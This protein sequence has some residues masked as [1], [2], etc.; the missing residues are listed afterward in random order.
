M[1]DT[2]VIALDPG[3]GGSNE[4]LK[5]QGLIEKEMTNV[6]AHTMKDTLLQY[7]QVEVYI[8]N[9]DKAD[10]SLKQRAEY[11][12]S[13]GADIVISLHFNMSENHE[14]FG[15]EVW[16]PSSGLG[17]ARMRALG[18]VFMEQ[19]DEM[20]MTL[21]GVKT[22]LNDRGSDYY[23]IIRESAALGIP[24]I[25]VEHGYADHAMDFEKVNDPEDW[26]A[27]AVSDAT[28]VAKY[29]RLKSSSLGNDYSDHVKNGY[30]APEQ[31]IGS[32]ATE[33]Q[34][35]SIRWD[36][37]LELTEEELLQLQSEQTQK[38]GEDSPE[39]W[40]NVQLFTIGATEEES[41]LVYYSYSYDGGETFSEVYPFA[42]DAL[43]MQIQIPNVYPG[44]QVCVR[45]YN[46]HFLY[47]TTDTITFQS[48]D[49]MQKNGEVTQQQID[50]AT[51][52]PQLEVAE[53]AQTELEESSQKEEKGAVDE[54]RFSEPILDQSQEEDVEQAGSEVVQAPAKGTGTF[55]AYLISSLFLFFALLLFFASYMTAKV[56]KKQYGRDAQRVQ[57]LALSSRHRMIKT[58]RRC[59]LI[60]MACVFVSLLGFSI[61]YIRSVN[62][63][64]EAAVIEQEQAEGEQNLE[65]ISAEDESI[66][67]QPQPEPQINLFLLP[68]A[69]TETAKGIQEQARFFEKE[70]IAYTTV[71]DIAEGYMRVPLLEQVRKN[72]YQL[73]AFS[74]TDLAKTYQAGDGKQATVGI[75]VSKFQGDIDWEAVS[76]S[77]VRFAIMR[78]GVRGYGSGELVMDDKFYVNQQAASEMGLRTGVYFFSQAINEAEAVEEAQFV[79][80]AISG[81][82]IDM[83]IVFDTEPINYDVARTDNLTPN[84]LTSITKA[85]CDTIRQAGYQPMIYANAKRF[86]TVL[87][88]DQL[89]DYSYW[90]ADYRQTPDYPYDFSMWQ[91]TEKGHVPGIE[92]NV[93]IDLFF[94]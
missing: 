94:E 89:T 68:L 52:I 45:I 46:G 22:R 70:E 35:A 15:S 78:L 91:F 2:L 82:S 26:K 27:M 67:E 18:D 47:T 37:K 21:R 42:K 30:F 12:K 65:E 83:P 71:Y 44:C 55:P 38:D 76:Q 49:E 63:T 87:H 16:I 1:P 93:D 60:G 6:V 81:L 4:G 43:S 69:L 3:H 56:R 59:L 86:T 39:V 54:N 32:D 51:Y 34:N 40:Q 90:L 25:L 72:P 19:F 9:P 5:H 80:D 62:M 41:D 36:G 75:D 85:F 31:P 74:G 50:A 53:E 23:G 17:Y 33:P 66:E 7:D 13:V 73:N 61:T 88:L 77:G 20:G 79:L 8:T 92:G 57:K 28:A 11:A 48:L 29:F 10:M 24:C 64:K 58:E 84:Q 14:M